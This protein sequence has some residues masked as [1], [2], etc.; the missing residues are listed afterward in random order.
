[1]LILIIKKLYN[2][3]IDINNKKNDIILILILIMKIT[4]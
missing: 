1:M 3:G 2:I 4:I